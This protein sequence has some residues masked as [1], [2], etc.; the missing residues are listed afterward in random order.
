MTAALNFTLPELIRRKIVRLTEHSHDDQMDLNGS[1]PWADGVNK[2][3]YPRRLDT[4]TIYGTPAWD[5]LSVEQRH[6]LCW[7]EAARDVSTFIWLEQT[8]PPLQLQLQQQRHLITALTG[9]FPSQEVKEKFVLGAL[10]LPQ[11][12]PVSL[13]SALVR[14]RPDVRA[15]EAH[16]GAVHQDHLDAEHVVGGQPILQA[17]HAARI[18]G[19]VAADRAGDLR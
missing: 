17:V 3:L 13:P 16:D 9:R 11:S 14:Q 10:R 6:Q 2:S 19:D 1:L 18:L 5:A 12:L 4:C 15:A 7:E 8:L